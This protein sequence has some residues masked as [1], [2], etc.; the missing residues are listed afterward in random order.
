MCIESWERFGNA[1]DRSSPR[2]GVCSPTRLAK[3]LRTCVET[4]FVVSDLYVALLS[5]FSHAGGGEVLRTRRYLDLLLTKVV[6]RLIT[7]LSSP[8]TR[9]QC[10]LAIDDSTENSICPRSRQVA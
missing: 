6:C 5:A 9:K 3:T 4:L 10:A 1:E 8:A 7:A 2:A